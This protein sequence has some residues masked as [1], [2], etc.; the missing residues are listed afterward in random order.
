MSKTLKNISLDSLSFSA[1]SESRGPSLRAWH[2]AGFARPYQSFY[3]DGIPCFRHH[4]VRNPTTECSFYF[5]STSY[6]EGTH[7]K[8]HYL[9]CGVQGKLA[10][11]HESCESSFTVFPGD[12]TKSLVNDPPRKIWTRQ[13]KVGSQGPWTSFILTVSPVRWCLQHFHIV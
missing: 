9:I 4:L 3:G 2:A 6:S 12:F 13:L 8:Y 10:H 1:V 7:A 5:L 11:S